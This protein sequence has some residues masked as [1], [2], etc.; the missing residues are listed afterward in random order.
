[1]TVAADA[2]VTNGH[3]FLDAVRAE[4]AKLR[5]IR[6]TYRTLAAA[7]AFNVGFA[8]IE[9]IFLPAH[10]S[11]HDKASLDAVR[12]SLGG[13]HLSQIAFGVLGVLIISSEYTTGMIRLTMA[14]IPNR[15]RLL[16]AKS[17]VFTLVATFTGVAISFAA[18]FV[19]QLLLRGDSLRSS[20]GDPGVLR[21]LLGGGIYLTVLGLL[22]L[23]L[24]TVLRSSAGAIAALFGLL[25]VP[26]VLVELL[27]ATWRTTIGPY[28]PMEAG[29]Q[30]FSQHRVAGALNPW[31]GLTVFSLY[32]IVALVAAFVLIERRD[33]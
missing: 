30:I 20:I 17:T 7:C 16:A 19:F 33:A 2:P 4:T 13:S 32:A 8:A 11:A 28:A 12:V 25:F 18:Y 6:S 14:A 31:L 24:G 1:M 15:R 5:S 23:G 3:L 26:Q 27:P 10:L 22:G 21:A 9:A 29:S